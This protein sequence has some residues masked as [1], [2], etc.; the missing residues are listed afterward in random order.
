MQLQKI[1]KKDARCTTLIY[2]KYGSGKTVT[3]LKLAQGI[4]K[5]I[6]L[7]DT[8]G[9][10]SAVYLDQYKFD[11]F[12]LSHTNKPTDYADAIDQLDKEGYDVIILDSIS[13]AW[14]GTNGGVLATAADLEREPEEGEKKKTVRGQLKWAL[15][16]DGWN[17]MLAAMRTVKAAMIVTA[18]EKE[19]F[20]AASKKSTGEFVPVMEKSTPYWFDAV[21]HMDESV[22]TV[23]KLVHADDN[24]IGA[25]INKPETAILKRMYDR[26]L[27]GPSAEK[28][29]A[30]PALQ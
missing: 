25:T 7:L 14:D 2:G 9:R 8:E 3:A 11:A 18:K 27:A 12:D 29:A 15:A 23:E 20:D 22:A 30:A 13:E 21:L 24:A 19:A 28:V 17:R 1:T 10:R 4:G 5:K 6:A 26:V 16:K